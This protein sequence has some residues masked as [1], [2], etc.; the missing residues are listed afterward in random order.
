M[1]VYISTM[2]ISMLIILIANKVIKVKNKKITLILAAIPLIIT[3]GFR[4][5]VGQDYFSYAK[6]FELA[7]EGQFFDR[8]EPGFYFI[9]KFILLFTDNYLWMFVITSIIYIMFVFIAIYNQSDNELFSVYL[10]IAIGY[11]FAFFNGMRQLLAVSIFFYGIKY[12]KNRKIIP[13]AI[14]II[15]AT[16]IHNSTILL[17][18]LYFLYGKKL[19]NYQFVIILLISIIF[20]PIILKLI[21]S[22][23]ELSKYSNYIGSSFDKSEKSYIQIYINLTILVFALFYNRKKIEANTDFSFYC[24]LHLIYTI[25]T[26]Y[27]GDIPLISR[28]RWGVGLPLIILIPK[29]INRE[30]KKKTRYMFIVG[31]LLLHNRYKKL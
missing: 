8:I 26:F 14:C 4:Y 24:I 23:V 3:S 9:I 12:I 11:Y 2:L 22:I 10:F 19:K 20:K 15:I 5:G 6:T 21:L 25:I 7:S 17:F 30:K 28:I 31:I 29:I 27:I 16:L 1:T 18:P 13:Y